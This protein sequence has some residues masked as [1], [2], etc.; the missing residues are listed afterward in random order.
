MMHGEPATAPMHGGRRVFGSSN[1]RVEGPFGL[2]DR[3]R[4]IS[5]VACRA[6][7][8]LARGGG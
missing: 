7:L 8:R 6:Y 4:Y 5:C 2:D 3:M 1:G